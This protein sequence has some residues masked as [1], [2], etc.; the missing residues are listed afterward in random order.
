MRDKP[1]RRVRGLME[2]DIMRVKQS[3]ALVRLVASQ[4]H[5][6]DSL[7]DADGYVYVEPLEEVSDWY[8]ISELELVERIPKRKERA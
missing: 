3:G 5:D 6:N 8:N 1:R 4:D 2:G 7:V